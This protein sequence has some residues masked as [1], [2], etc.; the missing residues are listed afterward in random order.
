LRHVHIVIRA[1]R[2]F[3]AFLTSGHFDRSIRYN[4][5]RVRVGL[6]AAPS[7][8]NPQRERLMKFTSD[9]L[10][11]GRKD[12]I[13]LLFRKLSQIPIYENSGLLQDPNFPN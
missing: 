11:R 8:P 1:S 13:R 7:L 2:F 6:S 9:N 3:S 5:I 12:K 4:L 10:V